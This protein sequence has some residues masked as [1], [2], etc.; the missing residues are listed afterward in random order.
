LAFDLPEM[1]L[2]CLHVSEHRDETIV[3]RIWNQI[4]EEISREEADTQTKADALVSRIVSLGKRFYPSDSAFPL[5]YIAT[6]LV[7]IRIAH[8]KE[9]PYGW[10]PRTLIQCGVLFVEAWDVLHE[11]YES[12]VPPFND[13]ANVQTISSDIAVLLSDWLEEAKRPQSSVRR[14]EFPVSRIDGAID[15]YLAELEPNRM[16][17]RKTYEDI[18]RQLRRYW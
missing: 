2:L 9:L 15:Q 1:Q 3:R 4:F 12:Q 13:Q 17:T 10:A 6:L 16:E 14:G 8:K 18:K 5:Q 7:R 11:M